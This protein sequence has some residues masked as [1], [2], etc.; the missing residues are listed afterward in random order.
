MSYLF[1]MNKRGGFFNTHPWY[2]N[3]E[4]STEMKNCSFP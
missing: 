3:L 4:K 2:D 1:F